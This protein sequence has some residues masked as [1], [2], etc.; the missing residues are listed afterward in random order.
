MANKNSWY[1]QRIILSIC[2]K[3]IVHWYRHKLVAIFKALS[4]RNLFLRASYSMNSDVY[5]FH[6]AWILMR[7]RRGHIPFSGEMAFLY[8]FAASA[9]FSRLALWRA[10]CIRRPFKAQPAVFQAELFTTPL[11]SSLGDRL[12]HVHCR[13][14]V[15]QRIH[16]LKNL[17]E[18]TRCECVAH[19]Y[20]F[21]DMR[22]GKR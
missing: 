15:W 17:E 2:N 16:M 7:W 1:T 21:S 20:I 11:C 10:G 22:V 6:I 12:M 5:F 9:A 3:N 8:C 4:P 18:Y 14:C 19:S 13:L